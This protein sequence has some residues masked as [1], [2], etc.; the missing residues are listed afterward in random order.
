M[1]CILRLTALEWS[2]CFT[3]LFIKYKCKQFT[4]W[5]L[6]CTCI[7]VGWTEGGYKSS[8]SEG[9]VFVL[10]NVMYQDM[11][12]LV[13]SSTEHN[14]IDS[15]A[16]ITS[17]EAPWT[18]VPDIVSFISQFISC[19]ISFIHVLSLNY[20]DLATMLILIMNATEWLS[21][22]HCNFFFES[23]LC[24]PMIPLITE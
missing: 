20:S 16:T 4:F 22:I 1:E 19:L 2:L 13:R 18:W 3:E 24:S 10:N 7:M 21:M 14:D 5:N 23:F 15:L 11:R 6:C 17:P 8:M 9:T 12:W